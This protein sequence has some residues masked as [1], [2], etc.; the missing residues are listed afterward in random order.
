MGV[1]KFFSSSSFDKEQFKSPGV[2]LVE[3]F[4]KYEPRLPNPDPLNFKITKYERVDE[5]IIIFINY[6]DCTNYEGNKILVFKNLTLGDLKAQEMI[7][8]HFSESKEFH[9]PIARFEPTDMGWNLAIRFIKLI[10]FE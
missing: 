2:P 7:D 6:P 1:I 3:E 4:E 10:D 5:H 9:S 8:P